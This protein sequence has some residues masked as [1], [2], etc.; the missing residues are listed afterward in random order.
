MRWAGSTCSNAPKPR[1]TVG[2]L[3][4]FHYFDLPVKLDHPTGAGALLAAVDAAGAG[5]VVLDGLNAFVT[6][7]EKDDQPWRD[8]YTYTI[9]PLKR[10]G[11]AVLSID[12]MG[13]DTSLGPRGSS[14]KMDKADAILQLTRTD[15]GVELK[16]THRRT[17]AYPAQQTY[18]AVLG[19]DDETPVAYR[20]ASTSWPAGT[21]EK[22]DE[23][24]RAAVPRDASPRT[25]AAALRCVGVAPGK[26]AVLVAAIRY[27]RRREG[28]SI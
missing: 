4:D 20:H 23:L 18:Q 14:V 7:A 9:A 22:A 19:D 3:D 25:A 17:A 27:R 8:L 24:D 11:V 16:A 6:G 12:N 5:V 1:L 2:D 26:N 10:R 21:A 13:K 15:D 28:V